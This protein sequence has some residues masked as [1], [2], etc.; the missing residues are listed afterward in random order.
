ML[1]IYPRLP[2][3]RQCLF[4]ERDSPVISTGF[5]YHPHILKH[6]NF[7]IHNQ[8]LKTII[9][10]ILFGCCSNLHAFSFLLF[11]LYL[12]LWI[13]VTTGVSRHL[14][15]MNEQKWKETM[16]LFHERYQQWQ[17]SWECLTVMEIDC[18]SL[19]GVWFYWSQCDTPIS[20]LLRYELLH[21]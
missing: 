3:G 10:Y 9:T 15:T 4:D 20:P 13:S 2:C 19:W 8:Q 14:L 6:C 17:G 16:R 12:T 11:C 21:L 7:S 5:S 18:R 1:I